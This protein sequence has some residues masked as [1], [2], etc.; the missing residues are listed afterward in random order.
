MNKIQDGKFINETFYLFIYL[1]KREAI[2]TLNIASSH[3]HGPPKLPP[4]PLYL[5]NKLEFWKTAKHIFNEFEGD[6]IWLKSF[7]PGG[8]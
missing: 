1:K 6:H 4:L 8:L 2:F 5:G 3:I 7:D